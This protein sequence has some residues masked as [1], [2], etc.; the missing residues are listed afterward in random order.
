M[1]PDRP[2]YGRPVH[3]FVKTFL[4]SSKTFVMRSTAASGKVLW[5]TLDWQGR[6]PANGVAGMMLRHAVAERKRM[7]PNG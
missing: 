5:Q 2:Q 3:G 7:I 6:G 1:K 4:P